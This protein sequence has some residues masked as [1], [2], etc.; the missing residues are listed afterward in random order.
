MVLMI[1]GMAVVTYLTRFS[2]LYLFRS[3]A[4]PE[5]VLR[6]FRLLP[7]GILAAMITPGLIIAD[8][9][10]FIHWQNV[11]L[12]AGIVSVMAALRWKSMFAS[13]GA[14]LVVILILNVV[15]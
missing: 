5:A 7:I 15:L 14:G 11:Y 8:G 3:I 2:F 4:L 9:Q 1:T 10:I 6:G 12:I 13:L